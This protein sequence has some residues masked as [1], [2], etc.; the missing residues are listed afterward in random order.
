MIR[1]FLDTNILADI[2]YNRNICLDEEQIIF[3]LAQNKR[4]ELYISALSFINVIY[5]CKTYKLEQSKVKNI[6]FNISKFLNVIDLKATDTVKM[7]E[8]DWKD[9]ED[10]IQNQSAINCNAQYIITRDSDGFLKSNIKI[11]NPKE[12]LERI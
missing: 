7:L 8:T 12:F 1:A 2:V 4:I 6:L 5:I 3:A 10:S 9:Y 11:V